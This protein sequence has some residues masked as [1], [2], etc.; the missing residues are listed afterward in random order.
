V[1]PFQTKIKLTHRR[2]KFLF[3]KNEGLIICL[4]GD[5]EDGRFAT[6]Q[7]YKFAFSADFIPENF[8]INEIGAKPILTLTAEGTN[9]SDLQLQ[10]KAN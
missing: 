9:F 6:L 2:I 3:L 4:A 7:I 10:F 1:Q 8:R 5:I